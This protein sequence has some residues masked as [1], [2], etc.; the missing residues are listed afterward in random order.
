MIREPT[1]QGNY[2]PLACYSAP[3]DGPASVPATRGG[4]KVPALRSA[5]MGVVQ[6]N[7]LYSSATSW[8]GNT[9]TSSLDKPITATVTATFAL[10]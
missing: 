5:K 7:P 2:G 8:E 9:H 4:S 6:I 10:R 3:P 1:R